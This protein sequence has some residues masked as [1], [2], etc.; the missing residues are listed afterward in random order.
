MKAAAVR[1][2]VLMLVLTA[3]VCSFSWSADLRFSACAFDVS[4]DGKRLAYPVLSYDSMADPQT[5]CWICSLDGTGK[6]R[7]GVLD[8]YWDLKWL[9]SD[10][11]AALHYDQKEVPIFSVS[12]GSEKK[13]SLVNDIMWKYSVVSPDGK[14]IVISTLSNRGENEGVF[15]LDTADGKL[16]KLTGDLVKSYPAW[17][18]DSRKIA[19]GIGGYQKDYKLMVVDVESGEVEDLGI[20]GIGAGWSPDGEWIAY[21]GDIVKGGSWYSGVPMDGSI[22]KT[23]LKTMETAVLTDKAVNIYTEEPM[24]WE[25]SGTFSPVWSPDGKRIAYRRVRETYK[26]NSVDSNE[27]QLWVM[28][29][30]GSGKAKILSIY[31]VFAWSP[32]SKSILA[33]QDNAIVRVPLDAKTPVK[34]VGW[35]EASVPQPAE[36]DWKTVSGKGVEVK[37]FRVPEEYAAAIMKVAE[38][39]RG[40]CADTYGCD[41]PQ[42]LEII[43]KKDPTVNTAL[44][45]D[46][47][48]VI[49]LTVENLRNLGPPGQSGYYNIYGICRSIGHLAMSR[50]VTDLGLDNMVVTGWADYSGSVLI[51]EVYKKLGSDVW[52]V[53]YDYSGEGMQRLGDRLTN[54]PLEHYGYADA[55]TIVLYN[56][57]RKYGTDKIFEAMREAVEGESGKIPGKDAIPRFIEALVKV[58]GDESARSIFPPK[59][60]SGGIKWNISERVIN[61]KTVEGLK[62]EKDETG[63]LLRYDDGTS[64]GKR[65]IAGTGHAVVYKCPPGKWAA[66]SVQFFGSRY[67]MPYPP[68]EDFYIYICD[69][70]FNVIREVRESYYKLET[71]DARW[72]TFK[73]DPVAVPEGFYVCIAFNPTATKGFYMNYDES[74]GKS[75]SRT[76]L[77][78]TYFS[79]VK[80]KYDWMIR[81]HLKKLD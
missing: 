2:I 32:D 77:P 47:E 26:D 66:D 73:F 27:D 60:V 71:G 44:W 4:P 81:V 48:S 33:K 11:V 14:R 78:W 17:S 62:T 6:K 5:E 36:K 63:V 80:G 21:S 31:G 16:R 76:A 72:Y 28:N 39:A 57:D 22:V 51:D 65:S 43:L 8:G 18:P 54:P 67:G 74:V 59:A 61:D 9:D 35:K 42:K 25:L 68:K 24:S 53:P 41:M 69:Q 19:Y 50:R 13:L 20:N 38:A 75:H 52:P 79:D 15:V 45:D 46:G 70:G 49:C 37:Y 23:N 58:T 3:A 55:T 64:E 34:V 1:S 56:A 12:G 7:L 30:D 10:R 29:A 40:V